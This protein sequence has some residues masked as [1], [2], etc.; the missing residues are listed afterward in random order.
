MRKFQTLLVALVLIL[1]ASAAVADQ[2]EPAPAGVVNINTADAT[3]LALLPGIGSKTGERIVAYRDENG[4]F[5][6]ATD[7]M[8]VKGIGEKTFERLRPYLVVE[9]KTTLTSEVK[10]PRKASASSKASSQ[11]P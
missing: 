4:P 5:K 9:G 8:Q 7:L 1:S 2:A 10:T 3:Q 6:K 11:A